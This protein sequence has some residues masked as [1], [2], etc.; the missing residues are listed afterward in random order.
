MR[1]VVGSEAAISRLNAQATGLVNTE[2]L[3]R[4]LLRAESVASSRVEGRSG[5]KALALAYQTRVRD[6]PGARLAIGPGG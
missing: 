3:A 2:P 6:V 4:I 1:A 5:M